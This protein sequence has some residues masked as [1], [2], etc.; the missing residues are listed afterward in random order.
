MI[1]SLLDVLEKEDIIVDGGNSHYK[2]SLERTEQIREHGLHFVD[3]GTSGGVWGLEEG[4]SMMV[5]GDEQEVEYLRPIFADLAP[6]PEQGWGYVGPN[7]AGH[8]VKMV[9]NGSNMA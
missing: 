6:G 3:V 9:H 8:F 4:Y 7:G 1:D 2:N 5:G